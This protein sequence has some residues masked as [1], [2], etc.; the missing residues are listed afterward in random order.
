[1][2]PLSTVIRSLVIKDSC[3]ITDL[4]SGKEWKIISTT[5]INS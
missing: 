3:S 2:P 4:K 5:G 1:M